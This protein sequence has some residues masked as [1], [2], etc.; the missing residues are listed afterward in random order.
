M[1]RMAWLVSS[2]MAAGSIWRKRVPFASN[3]DTPSVV[4][5][6]YGVSS[7]ASG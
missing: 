7:A 5:N 3:V 6:L 1:S 2:V 4:S